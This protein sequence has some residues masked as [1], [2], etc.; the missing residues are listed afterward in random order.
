VKPAFLK[1]L[2]VAGLATGLWMALVPNRHGALHNFLPET[3]RRWVSENDDPANIA[4]FFMLTLVGLRLPRARENGR[5]RVA[6]MVFRM[7]GH[8]LAKVGV[9]MLLVCAI[10]LS[11]RF[12]PGRVGELQDVCTGWSGIF[13]AWL[14]SVL[15][16]ARAAASAGT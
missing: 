16:D 12:I 9:L 1:T 14:L 6:S 3:L 8:P 5:G 11:Q 13:A 10:E 15:R 4:G 7:L 2:F